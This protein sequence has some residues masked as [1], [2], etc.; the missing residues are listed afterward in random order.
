[1][2]RV[3]ESEGSHMWVWLNIKQEGQTAGFGP[4]KPLTR[5]THFGSSGFWS[6]S[7]VLAVLVCTFILD[8]SE[9]CSRLCRRGRHS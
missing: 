3:G 9:A 6:H 5:A 4:W 2:S 8:E 7:H 1:M